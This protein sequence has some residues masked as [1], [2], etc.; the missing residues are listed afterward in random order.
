MPSEPAAPDW[1]SHGLNRVAPYRLAIA[2]AAA[3]PRLARLPL[4][5]S[6]FDAWSPA[7]GHA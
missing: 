1:S 2:S 3:R 6:F 4:P 7:D 5:R